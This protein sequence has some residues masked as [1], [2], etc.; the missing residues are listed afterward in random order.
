MKGSSCYLRAFA[1]SGRRECG[2]TLFWLGTRASFGRALVWARPRLGCP[3]AI[4]TTAASCLSTVARA[5]QPE[6]ML[7][8]TM[9][10][11]ADENA[12]VLSTTAAGTTVVGRLQV[13]QPCLLS[14]QGMVPAGAATLVTIAYSWYCKKNKPYHRQL[15]KP[16]PALSIGCRSRFTQVAPTAR[17]CSSFVRICSPLSTSHV[18]QTVLEGQC[19]YSVSQLDARLHKVTLNQD[20]NH[21]GLAGRL[22][23]AVDLVLG[24]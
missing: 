20:F 8:S 14:G 15:P 23:T 4:V 1:V 24:S 12:L 2:R 7:T 19:P 22:S 9:S 6:F 16:G 5:D 17:N 10:P 11:R 3:P 13:S 18:S 21:E